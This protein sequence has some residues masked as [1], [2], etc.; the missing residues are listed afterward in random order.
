MVKEKISFVSFEVIDENL[1]TVL[2]SKGVYLFASKS[3]ASDS[4]YILKVGCTNNLRKSI[5]AF[6]NFL[7]TTEIKDEK[8]IV[9]F[10]L[11]DET[12]RCID[13]AHKLNI[14]Y[15]NTSPNMTNIQI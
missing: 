14:K 5:E 13:I 3:S 7:Q 6:N 10:Y 12:Q 2:E 8:L 1:K 9:N 15:G 11:C 4:L